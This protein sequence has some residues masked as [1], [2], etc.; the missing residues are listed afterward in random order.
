MHYELGKRNAQ[1]I[2]AK[3]RMKEATWKKQNVGGG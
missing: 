3:A 2:G 1:D